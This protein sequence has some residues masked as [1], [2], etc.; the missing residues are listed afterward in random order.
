M[1]Q[2]AVL[3]DLAVVM[4]VAAMVTIVFRQFKQPV[5]LGYILAG[6][7]LNG[8]RYIAA[9]IADARNSRALYWTSFRKRRVASSR[10]TALEATAKVKASHPSRSGSGSNP[11]SRRNTRHEPKATRLFP[12]TKG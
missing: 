7:P 12:S 4:I 2:I 3:Q 5:V 10:S 9:S 11:F 6:V 8:K 1:H